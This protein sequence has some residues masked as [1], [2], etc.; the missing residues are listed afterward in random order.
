MALECQSVLRRILYETSLLCKQFGRKAQLVD[1]EQKVGFAR[2][3]GSMH[4]CRWLPMLLVSKSAR[5][6]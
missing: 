4:R 3:N 2:W 1:T 6:G 5:Q